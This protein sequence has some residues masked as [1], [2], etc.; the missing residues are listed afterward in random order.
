M[1]PCDPSWQGARVFAGKS[2]LRSSQWSSELADGNGGG[3]FEVALCEPDG[4]GAQKM[5]HGTFLQDPSGQWRV[6]REPHERNC[7]VES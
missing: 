1:N 2:K 6:T 4:K 5:S 7:S 3:A